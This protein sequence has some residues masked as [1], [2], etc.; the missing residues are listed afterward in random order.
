MMEVRI[1][2]G[3]ESIMV[4][5]KEE[6]VKKIEQLEQQR[7]QAVTLIKDGRFIEAL[8]VLENDTNR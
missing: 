4:D 5:E 1:S 2:K 8:R 3:P 6:Y 7:E